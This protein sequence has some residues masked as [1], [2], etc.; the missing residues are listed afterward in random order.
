ME[1]NSMYRYI[2][3]FSVDGSKLQKVNEFYIWIPTVNIIH[4]FCAEYSH[5]MQS[6][7]MCNAIFHVSC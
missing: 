6:V 7:Y 5:R 1:W 4:C 3:I 2:I